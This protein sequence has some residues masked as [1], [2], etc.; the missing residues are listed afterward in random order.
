MALNF[1]IISVDLCKVT[2]AFRPRF[3]QCWIE[4]LPF[5]HIICLDWHST[6]QKNPRKIPAPFAFEILVQYWGPDISV[7]SL[8]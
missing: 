7:G 3:K 6:L 8:V 1:Q 5:N 2:A 4:Q